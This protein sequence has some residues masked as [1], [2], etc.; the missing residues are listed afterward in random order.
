MVRDLDLEVADGELLVLLG[1]SGSGKTTT[2]RIVAG[3]ETPDA[4]EVLVGGRP[5]AG[6][7]PERRNVGM[8]FQSHALFPHKRVA[9]N[10]GYGLLA[11]G[12]PREEVDAA[13]GGGR[14]AAADRRPA[15][16]GCRASCRAASASASPS[17][18]RS[19]ATPRCC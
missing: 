4:G 8:V 6:L 7:P 2:L 12:H 17:R 3:L 18:A 16:R 9:D 1:P 14:R 11:R 15:R 5:V 19:C 13:G 10:I